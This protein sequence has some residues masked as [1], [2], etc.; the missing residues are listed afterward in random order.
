[1]RRLDADDVAGAAEQME[2]L[3]AE[4][5]RREAEAQQRYATAIIVADQEA[6]EARLREI[7]ET[8]AAE[9][10]AMEEAMKRQLAA[11]EQA[12]RRQQAEILARALRKP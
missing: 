11:E 1:M 12:E 6:H 2:E 7:D 3:R 4:A 5:A 10:A 9:Q 8:A